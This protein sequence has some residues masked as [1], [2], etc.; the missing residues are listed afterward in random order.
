VSEREYHVICVCEEK[1]ASVRG[2][3]HGAARARKVN[4][5]ERERRKRES[6]CVLVNE[7]YNKEGEERRGEA[8]HGE[9][10]LPHSLTHS[11]P[12]PREEKEEQER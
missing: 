11:P 12:E 9:H 1:N 3:R 5:Q 6:V 4:R 10:S 8:R 2:C 7:K